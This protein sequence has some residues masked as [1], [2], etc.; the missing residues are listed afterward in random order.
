[1]T[2]EELDTMLG[3]L[4]KH[5]VESYENDQH[6]MRIRFHKPALQKPLTLGDLGLGMQAHPIEPDEDEPEPIKTEPKLPP[7]GVIHPERFDLEDALYGAK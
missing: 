3:T 7:E 5:N 2:T 6:G 1:M 4:A